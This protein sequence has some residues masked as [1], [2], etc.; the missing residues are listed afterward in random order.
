MRFVW[1]IRVV[2]GE[3]K[4]LLVIC[5]TNKLSSES[6]WIP[7]AQGF[8]YINLQEINNLLRMY[9]IFEQHATHNMHQG[10]SLHYL[11]SPSGVIKIQQN[12]DKTDHFHK[13]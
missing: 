8:V 11:I 9:V 3:I 1:F 5:G 4:M 13:I 12:S 10:K 6:I 2:T 7:H